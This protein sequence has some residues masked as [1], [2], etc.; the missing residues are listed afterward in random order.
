MAGSS[1]SGVSLTAGG[2][3]LLRFLSAAFVFDDDEADKAGSNQSP[4]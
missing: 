1:R 4:R 2:F 3:G